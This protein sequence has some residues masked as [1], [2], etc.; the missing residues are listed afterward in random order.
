MKCFLHSCGWSSAWPSNCPARHLDLRHLDTSCYRSLATLDVDRKLSG[1]NNQKG[2]RYR[3]GRCRLVIN[4]ALTRRYFKLVVFTTRVKGTSQSVKILFF[5]Q[6]T[7]GLTHGGSVS[8]WKQFI[9]KINICRL[10]YSAPFHTFGFSSSAS[11]NCCC[12]AT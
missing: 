1:L 3:S 6:P 10:S 7:G 5:I 2:R 4:L 11:G 8:L 9:M 12:Q